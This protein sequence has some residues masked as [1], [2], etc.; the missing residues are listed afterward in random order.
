MSDI[1]PVPFARALGDAIR[2]AR[3]WD[4]DISLRALS[5]RIASIGFGLAYTGVRSME[6]GNRKLGLAEALQLARALN[7]TL[8]DLIANC[9]DAELI[10]LDGVVI[11]KND[12]YQAV[13]GDQALF[14]HS[15]FSADWMNDD[16]LMDRSNKPD[17]R[18]AIATH[19]HR[20]MPLETSTAFLDLNQRLRF[21]SA[22]LAD[23][24][25]AASVN[26]PTTD[27]LMR[28]LQESIESITNQLSE[29]A[30]QIARDDA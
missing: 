3:R 11:S 18:L 4:G 16:L 10:D 26:S 17:V 15:E 29:L 6:Q 12:L 23:V 7:T 28:I 5:E 19:P 25:S 13:R 24:A 14:A 22:M 20:G 27:S 8:P 21:L 9:M 1:Q 2:E 30:E